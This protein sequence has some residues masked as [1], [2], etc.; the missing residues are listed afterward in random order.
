MLHYHENTKQIN[1]E[2]GQKK[3]Y[4]LSYKS[5]KYSI[6]NI[7]PSIFFSRLQH[8]QNFSFKHSETEELN[9]I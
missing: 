5:T 8:V 6:P 1:N 4:D 2:M 9:Y 3:K 7:I